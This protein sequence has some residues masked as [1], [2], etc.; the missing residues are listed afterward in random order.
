METEHSF[1]T[2]NTSFY[3]V[4]PAPNRLTEECR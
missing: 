1:A 3:N 4:F 2:R